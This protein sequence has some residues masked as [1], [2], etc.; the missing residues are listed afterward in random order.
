[1]HSTEVGVMLKNQL[2]NS[3]LNKTSKKCKSTVHIATLNITTLP[4]VTDIVCIQDAI[5][6][7]CIQEHRY[8]HSK[9]E[10]KYHD[11]SNG[12]T[13]IS[14]SAWKDSVNAVVGL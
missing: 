4:E 6:L 7:I 8:H 5:Y 2:Q 1:M 13:L 11:T 9:V 10:I 12:C 3:K 14:A